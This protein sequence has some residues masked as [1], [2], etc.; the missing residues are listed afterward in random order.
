M[1]CS[2]KAGNS[3]RCKHVIAALMFCQRVEFSKLD[4][5]SCTD[6]ECSWAKKTK[7]ALQQYEPMTLLDHSCMQ[8][9]KANV[10]N[11]SEEK[12][13]GINKNWL[14]FLSSAI[15]KHLCGRHD[16]IKHDNS[17]SH[18]CVNNIDVIIN[19]ANTSELMKKLSNL[20]V[21]TL[22]ECCQSTTY[23]LRGDYRHICIDSTKSLATW[24]EERIFRITSSRCY[25]LYTYTNNKKPNWE[26]KSLNYFYPKEHFNKY[27]RHEIQN[28]PIAREIYENHF[29]LKVHQ[30]SLIISNNN[31]WL[32]CSPDG[33]FE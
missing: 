18:D 20:D 24:K 4:E 3:G 31:P 13:E 28:E 5:L 26:R 7:E 16:V 17:V 1:R 19:R 23:R 10:V 30:C 22:K 29:Q 14:L 21:G 2:C 11:V 33:Y 12:R 32:A 6:V 8:K 15:K 27:V 25:E 9:I